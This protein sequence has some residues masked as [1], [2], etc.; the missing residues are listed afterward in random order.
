M[1]VSARPLS[2]SSLVV[3]VPM[4][5]LSVANSASRSPNAGRGRKML[6]G[7]GVESAR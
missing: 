2:S 1:A 6:T 7:E 5:V 3:N 4:E